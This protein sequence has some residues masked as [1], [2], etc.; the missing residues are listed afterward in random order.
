MKWA[1]V[2]AADKGKLYAAV[3]TDYPKIYNYLLIQ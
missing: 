2:P 3:S 1:D